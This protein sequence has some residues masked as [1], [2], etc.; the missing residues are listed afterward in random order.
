MLHEHV[1]LLEREALCLP[2][3]EVGVG[4]AQEAQR[5]PDEEYLGAEVLRRLI[6]RAPDVIRIRRLTPRSV[7]TMNGVITA[8]MQFQSQLDAVESATPL[9]RIGMGKI[10]PTQTHAAG[11]QVVEKKKMYMQ[12]K[13]TCTLRMVCVDSAA[14]PKIAVMNSQ[15]VMPTDHQ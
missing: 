8:M 5:A 12:M 11:P 3:E 15:T 14:T 1:D 7:S 10:S 4:Y 9:E 6:S 2:D 13:A